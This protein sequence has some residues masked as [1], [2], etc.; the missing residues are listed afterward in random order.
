MKEVHEVIT[1]RMWYHKYL[2]TI[3]EVKAI[4]DHCVSRYT[5]VYQPSRNQMYCHVMIY[6]SV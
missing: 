2:K 4:G 3:H 1:P 6:K 5:H